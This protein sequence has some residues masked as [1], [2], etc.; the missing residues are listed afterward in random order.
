MTD[1]APYLRKESCPQCGG[2][3]SLAVYADHVHC[4]SLGCGYHK[5]TD[6][7]EAPKRESEKRNKDLL[8]TTPFEVSKRGITPETFAFWRYGE[9]E[10]KGERVHVATHFVDGQATGQKIRT[11]DK[12][13]KVLGKLDPLY[14]RWLWPQGGR[15]VVV[16]EGEL[17]ALSVSQ[18]FGNKWPVVSISNGAP[19][20]A[21]S[22]KKAIEWLRAFDEVVIL[23]DQDE[24]GQAAAREAAA[25]LPPGKAKIASLPLKDANDMLKAGR[26]EEL[27][28]ATWNAVP[29]R[30]D[31]IVSLRDVIPE[32]LKP[33][34]IGR[35]WFL[36]TLT[37]LTYGRRP[38]E[39]YMLGAGTGVGKTDFLTEQ[40][41]FDL[42]H[43][44]VNTGVLFLEQ[45]KRETVQRIAGKL[46]SKR[47]HVPDGSW[48]QTELEA[49]LNSLDGSPGQLYLYDNFG[50]IDW[51]TIESRIEY[52]VQALGCEHVYLD[53][54]TALAAGEDD[55][56]KALEDIMARLAGL[57]KRLR[58]VMHV[59]SHLSTPEGTPHEEGGRVMIRHFKGSR[60]IGFWSYFMFGMERNQ[61]AEDVAERSITTFR[62]LKDRYTGQATGQTIRLGYDAE[63]GRLF[64]MAAADEAFTAEPE[65]PPEF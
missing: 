44:K 52:M 36:P 33:V 7:S 27:V 4:F 10:L 55:E 20:A 38:G 43:Q 50:A 18:A 12:D 42:M 6:G 23:F 58:I 30:P 60:S 28:K 49:A 63:T 14:G 37:Q 13:F 16:V 51:P 54:L 48:T 59:V 5:F 29:W 57:A 47:F 24:V 32:A 22:F 19:S 17:D 56:R 1:S 26:V 34:E 45:D 64:E 25:V 35:P 46:A 8:T 39:V 62:V 40:I 11:K 21:I 61:Q 3:D 31:G 53:H 2:S 41:L 15:R 65:D 9:A